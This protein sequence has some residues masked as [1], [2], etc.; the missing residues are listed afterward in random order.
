MDSR[1][2]HK[3]WTLISPDVF[4][5]FSF[6]LLPQQITALHCEQSVQLATTAASGKE[7]GGNARQITI[8]HSFDQ[9]LEAKAAGE[10]KVHPEL[11]AAKPGN[12]SFVIN[13]WAEISDDTAAIHKYR[14]NNWPRFANPRAGRIKIVLVLPPAH[15][16][17]GGNHDRCS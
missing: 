13:I 5:P 9:P 11:I 3:R 14:K 6:A 2:L 8:A 4:V 16:L 15:H 12:S 1:P 7:N 10:P 17:S